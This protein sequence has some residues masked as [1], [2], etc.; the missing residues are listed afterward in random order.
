MCK[1]VTLAPRVSDLVE[2]YDFQK[3]VK[4]TNLGD[5]KECNGVA[6]ERDVAVPV[7]RTT[8]ANLPVP[9]FKLSFK[10]ERVDFCWR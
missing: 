2:R 5:N 1:S 6:E 8:M 9:V 7:R 3:S 10:K 4:I